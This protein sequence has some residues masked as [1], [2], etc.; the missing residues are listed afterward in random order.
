MEPRVPARVCAV[1]SRAPWRPLVSRDGPSTECCC[2]NGSAT[3]ENST[4][5]PQPPS[6]MLPGNVASVWQNIRFWFGGSS[7]GNLQ[8][9]EAC[10]D[11]ACRLGV[12]RPGCSSHKPSHEAQGGWDVLW[13][14]GLRSELTQAEAAS[15]PRSCCTVTLGERGWLA[16]GGLASRASSK[17]KMT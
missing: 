14:R 7:Q 3:S 2:P 1:G 11:S 10:C 6:Q 16:P 17:T 15:H 13:S 5:C 8:S 9:H 4:F 12:C